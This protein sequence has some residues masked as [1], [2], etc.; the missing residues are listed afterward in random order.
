MPNLIMLLTYINR[1]SNPQ[2]IITLNKLS[3]VVLSPDLKLRIKLKQTIRYHLNFITSLLHSKLNI[4]FEMR[5]FKSKSTRTMFSRDRI[6]CLRFSAFLLK[7]MRI[8]HLR[9]G[10]NPAQLIESQNNYCHVGKLFV[11][12]DPYPL[13]PEELTESPS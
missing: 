12:F 13:L 2:T 10:V 3:L 8:N 7:G 5:T 11:F 1:L 9:G 6:V 4:C